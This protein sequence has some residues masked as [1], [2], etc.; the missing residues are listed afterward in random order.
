M[1]AIH[2][3]QLNV[4]LLLQLGR[5]FVGSALVLGNSSFSRAGAQQIDL[6]P[7]LVKIGLPPRGLDCVWRSRSAA[8]TACIRSSSVARSS[9]RCSISST[10]VG[11][12]SAR[13]H[14]RQLGEQHVALDLLLSDLVG[15]TP[16]LHL[17][18]LQF[19]PL[20]LEGL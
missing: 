6:D 7:R 1:A 12:D 19:L 2:A 9:A 3:G 5:Q 8:P 18:G 4:E 15:V 13:C 16:D 17:G 14:G 11:R 20:T 10:R